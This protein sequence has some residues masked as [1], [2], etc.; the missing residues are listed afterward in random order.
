MKF[1]VLY[2]PNGTFFQNYL[3]GELNVNTVRADYSNIQ[4]YGV[5][6]LVHKTIF[7]E[8][9]LKKWNTCKGVANHQPTS[10]QAF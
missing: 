10:E 9:W 6:L 7:V 1:F 5:A 8:G 2:F 4:D 3:V